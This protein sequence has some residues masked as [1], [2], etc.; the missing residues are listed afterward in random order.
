[1]SYTL[2]RSRRRKKTLSIQV[3]RDGT[4]LIQVPFYTPQ[5][6]IDRFLKEKKQ[7]LQ[8]KILQ[9]QA[10]KNDQQ[11]RAFIPGERFPYLG[12][13]YVLKMDGGTDAGE[14]L[15]FTGREF[16]LRRH[17]L[18]GIRILFHLWYQKRA[19]LH[20]EERVRHFSRLMG[21]SP[22]GVTISNARSRWGSCS[23]DN[24]LTFA[25]RLIMAPPNVIDYVVIHELS[26]IKIRNHSRD[27]WRLV[28]RILPGCKEQKIWLKDHGHRLTI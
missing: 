11:T 12:E 27:Y 17:A 28:E 2:I 13:T 6:D 7:W 1:M 5:A 22:R 15:T 14:A 3:Q 20:L 16:L 21:L 4:V 25:W 10:R 24:Q 23:P 19:L 9:Q 8:Q 26:H 18:S